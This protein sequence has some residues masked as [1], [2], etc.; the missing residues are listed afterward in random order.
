[1]VDTKPETET[2]LSLSQAA[3]ELNVHPTTLRRWANNGELPYMLTPG[4]HRRFAL[5]S[6]RQF[7]AEQSQNMK[8]SNRLQDMW[9]EK[10]VTHTRQEIVSHEDQNWLATL[11][12]SSREQHRLLGRQLLGLTLQYISDPETNGNILEQARAVGL[13]YGRISRELGL[14]LTDALEAAMFFRDM[15]IEVALQLPEST[16]IQPEANVRLLRRINKLLNTVH[17]AIAELY[18]DNTAPSPLPRT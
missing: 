4:K 9:V 11:D 13:E 15:L 1:M 10:A 2:W 8:P 16:R 5:S 12:D 14:P 6:V 17:L 18:D 7:A 3:T